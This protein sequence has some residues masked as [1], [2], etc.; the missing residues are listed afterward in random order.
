[1]SVV[2]SMRVLPEDLGSS[3]RRL[4]PIFSRLASQA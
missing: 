4:R 1:M 3:A 2:G